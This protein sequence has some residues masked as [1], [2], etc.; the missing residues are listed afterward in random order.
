MKYRFSINNTQS[1]DDFN[2]RT[3]L[4]DKQ[5]KK[6][7]QRAYLAWAGDSRDTEK[8]F[9]KYSKTLEPKLRAYSKP[10]FTWSKCRVHSGT[11]TQ[12]EALVIDVIFSHFKT[13]YPL[14]VACMKAYLIL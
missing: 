5:Y 4:E 12:K 6:L 14:G 10:L 11:E 7:Q 2:Y 1:D 3:P 8:Y 9:S 13:Q